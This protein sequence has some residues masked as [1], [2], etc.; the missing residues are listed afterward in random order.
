M[1]PV[2]QS[3]RYPTAEH[4]HRGVPSGEWRRA[5]D[6]ALAAGLRTHLPAA[7]GI[8]LRGFAW[9]LV[10]VGVCGVLLLATDVFGLPP[11]RIFETLRQLVVLN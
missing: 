11:E 3:S 1:I 6:D 4:P 9:L 5:L 8:L 7:I 2:V 10:A